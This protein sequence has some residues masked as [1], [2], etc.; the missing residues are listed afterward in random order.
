VDIDIQIDGPFE[1]DIKPASIKK[2]LNSTFQLFPPLT[3]GTVAVVITNNQI[4]QQLNR[5]YRGIDAATDVLS[6]DN[7][8]D[9]DFPGEDISSHLGDIII[10]YPVAQ[11]QAAAG[12]H[13]TLE[14]VQLLAVHGALHLLGFDHDTPA[15]K[16]KMWT[17]QQQVLARL[18]LGHIQPTET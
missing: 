7:A 6:F 8:P 13:T 14:E 15:N 10:A 1:A 4:V 5:D 2:A 16:K 12:G 17:A 18:D 11:Q 9:A 3:E